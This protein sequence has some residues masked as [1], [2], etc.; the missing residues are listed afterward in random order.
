VI[1][2][3]KL[4]P[5]A[6]KFA[7]TVKKRVTIL[8]GPTALAFPLSSHILVYKH[9]LLNS[10]EEREFKERYKIEKKQLPILRMSDPIRVWYGW[11]KGGIVRIERPVG[12]VWRY[13]K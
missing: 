1:V 10:K 2:F 5:D 13:I 3:A 6:N 7:A 12:N 11:P 4:S 8:F 9:A